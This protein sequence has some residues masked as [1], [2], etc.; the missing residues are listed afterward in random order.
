MGSGA[1]IRRLAMRS[2]VIFVHRALPLAERESAS[3]TRAFT[4][5]VSS[6]RRVS[7]V[8]SAMRR[9]RSALDSKEISL[10]PFSCSRIAS[11][12]RVERRSLSFELSS[13]RAF[14]ESSSSCRDCSS[15]SSRPSTAKK[16]SGQ[17]SF[18]NALLSHS[19]R[20]LKLVAGSMPKPRVNFPH[21]LTNRLLRSGRCARSDRIKTQNT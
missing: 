19:S 15:H 5:S 4:S 2:T 6:G 3:M 9:S 21:H 1:I 10:I 7:T 18:F 16:T 14:S 11:A 13:E 8:F 20:A 17:S 12:G